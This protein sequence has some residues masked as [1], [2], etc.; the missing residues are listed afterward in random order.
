MVFSPKEG[1]YLK[2]SP[3]INLGDIGF[4][5]TESEWTRDLNQDLLGWVETWEGVGRCIHYFSF[6]A[7]FN[8]RK[9]AFLFGRELAWFKLNIFC[10]IIFVVIINVTYTDSGRRLGMQFYITLS[11]EVVNAQMLQ[12]EIIWDLKCYILIV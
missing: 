12:A 2:S 4:T 9:Q 5:Y 10:H 3:P 6:K 7:H 8:C 11:Y 1:R